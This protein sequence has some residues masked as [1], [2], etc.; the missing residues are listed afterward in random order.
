MHQ[1]NYN[2]YVNII[3]SSQS[4][5]SGQPTAYWTLLHASGLHTRIFPGGETSF[6]V[7]PWGWENPYSCQVLGKGIGNKFAETWKSQLSEMKDRLCT[8]NPLD[9]NHWPNVDPDTPKISPEKK[10]ECKGLFSE[11][12][13]STGGSPWQF[14]VTLSSMKLSNLV[15][16]HPHFTI[17]PC[18]IIVSHQ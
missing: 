1:P 6:Q 15:E 3:Q 8:Y 7:G 5:N 13:D 9:I 17:K 10:E 16:P 4:I 11:P 12:H 2:W 18:L 14:C